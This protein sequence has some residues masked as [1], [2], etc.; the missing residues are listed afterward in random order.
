MRTASFFIGLILLFAIEI[1]RVYFIMPF[2]G[3]QQSD[4]VSLAYFLNNNIV[5][6]RILAFVLVLPSLWYF[7]RRG[8]M[9]HKVLLFAVVIFYG[10]VFYFFNFRFL[11][12]KMFY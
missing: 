8:R 3:S 1:S 10:V 5:L 12:D 6:L 11:A 4:T 7:F 2:P 9:G